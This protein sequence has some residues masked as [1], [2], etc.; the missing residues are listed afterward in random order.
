[1]LGGPLIVPNADETS[2]AAIHQIITRQTHVG[3]LLSAMKRHQ[4]SG[5]KRCRELHLMFQ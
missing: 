2:G 3:S 4:R 1:V 5:R